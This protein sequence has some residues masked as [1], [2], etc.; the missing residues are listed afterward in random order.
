MTC[1]VEEL[2]TAFCGTEF[3]IAAQI[4]LSTL[5]SGAGVASVFQVD[6]GMGV[7]S[8]SDLI[9]RVRALV[10]GGNAELDHESVS[11]G[12]FWGRLRG[13][14]SRAESLCTSNNDVLDLVAATVIDWNDTAKDNPLIDCV[15]DQ[16]SPWVSELPAAVLRAEMQPTMSR[17]AGVAS[18]VETA[19][20]QQIAEGQRVVSQS[21]ETR[22][23]VTRIW[24]TERTWKRPDLTQ[25][26]ITVR[27]VT[28][29]EITVLGRVITTQVNGDVTASEW[30][31]TARYEREVGA[32][33]H[34]VVKR[35]TI[36]RI[37]GTA[38]A[39]GVT[40][41]PSFVA[42]GIGPALSGAIAGALR[43]IITGGDPLRGAVAGAM[44]AG[45]ASVVGD[46]GL[47]GGA[48]VIAHAAAGGGAAA[49]SGGDVVAA[50]VGTVA[51]QTVSQVLPPPATHAGHLAQSVFASSAAA[52]V[53]G[54]PVLDAVLSAVTGTIFNDIAHYRQNDPRWAEKKI[55]LDHTGNAVSIQRRGCYLVALTNALA[56]FDAYAAVTPLDV[57]TA[58]KAGMLLD[59]SGSINGPAVTR[60]FPR[61][62]MLTVE[63]RQINGPAGVGQMLSQGKRVIA[64]VRGAPTHFVNVLGVAAD[65]ATLNVFDPGHSSVNSKTWSEVMSFRVLSA[66]P[67][68]QESPGYSTK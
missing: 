56:S 6:L 34:K 36:Q 8:A 53:T 62:S 52:A 26:E 32:S 65:G 3:D 11:L 45:F 21:A 58:A 39:I 30:R 5:T 57:L 38:V 17:L 49:I 24:H 61:V 13:A 9:E 12:G 43:P 68:S 60:V 67:P 4:A 35:S 41:A 22:E 47:S 48:K 20:R 23:E 19:V 40:Y 63:K 1:S 15:L 16:L 50:V 18:L 54:A 25:T 31:V 51:A 10:A 27:T 66:R 55:G 46:A 59:A 2:T 42:P 14:A 28:H 29:H 44:Q 64:C 33:T 37:A 7:A